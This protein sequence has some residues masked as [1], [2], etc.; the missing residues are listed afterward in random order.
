MK[1]ILRWGRSAYERDADL[2]L[3]TSLLDAMGVSV[4]REPSRDVPSEWL[5]VADAL[6][7]TSGVRVTHD[8]LARLRGSYLLTTTSG[9]DHIDM[10]AARELGVSV[11]AP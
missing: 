6:V 5:P 8:V 3:E 9:Y 10:E 2:A 11:A 4:I 7:V 1:T